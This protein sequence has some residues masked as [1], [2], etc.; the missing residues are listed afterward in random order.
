MVKAY[1]QI[2]FNF[3]PTYQNASLFK[4]FANNAIFPTTGRGS[5]L[6]PCDSL[7]KSK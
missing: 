4:L 1:T 3:V 2:R 5:M 6:K 7:G